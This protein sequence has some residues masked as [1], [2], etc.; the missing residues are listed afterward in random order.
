MSAPQDAPLIDIEIED[1]A[2]IEALPQVVRLV[3]GAI[4]A[5]LSHRSKPAACDIVVL[6]TDD[7]EMQSLNAQYRKKNA[8][9]NVLS[10]PTPKAMKS[11]IKGHLGDLALGFG[12]CAKEAAEQ[13]KSL[14]DHLTHLC[15]HGTLHLLG[16]DHQDDKEAQEMEALERDI[17]KGLGISDPYKDDHLKTGM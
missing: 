14:S 11:M 4:G 17:L 6:L 16:Y 5:A 10:F 12:I 2:W 1:E 13:N 7:A 3:E 8:P 15:V 9:T